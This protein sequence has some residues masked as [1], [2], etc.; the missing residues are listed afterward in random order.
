MLLSEGAAF[1]PENTGLITSILM[2]VKTIGQI[3][4]PLAVS[5]IRASIGET[6]GMLLIAAAFLADGVA[7][8]GL[9]CVKKKD[10]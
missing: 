9:I 10:K 2:I 7:V 3:L 5:A 1:S 8:A 6:A 4:M